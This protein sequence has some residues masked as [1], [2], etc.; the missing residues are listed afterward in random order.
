MIFEFTSPDG[1]TYEVEGPEGSTPEDAFKRLQAHI[2]R[3]PDTNTHF[4]R[5][6]V[7]ATSIPETLA[8]I[9]GL[10][11]AAFRGVQWLRKKFGD[12]ATKADAEKTISRLDALPSIK[13][14]IEEDLGIPTSPQEEA[15]R[16]G[17]KFDR[18]LEALTEGVKMATGTLALG[19]T[20]RLAALA[21]AGAGT[22][23]LVDQEYG[24]LAGGIGGTLLGAKW[25]SAA[26]KRA[27]GKNA[28]TSDA[29]EKQAD[30]AFARMRQS[31]AVVSQS[32]LQRLGQRI[33]ADLNRQNFRPSLHPQTAIIA[34]ELSD[35]I[36]KGIAQYTLPGGVLRSGAAPM[37]FEQLHN[38]R[39]VIDAA[40][41]NA[42]S[43]LM[44]GQPATEDMRLLSRMRSKLNDFLGNLQQSD[45]VG[46]NALQAAAALK[47][48]SRAHQKLVKLR[49]IEDL[50]ERARNNAPGFSQASLDKSIRDQFKNL[51]NKPRML[52]MFSPAE[53]AQIRMIS[54]SSM[55]MA[56]IRRLGGMSPRGT[57]TN[58][59][60]MAHVAI[61][62]AVGVP[63]AAATMGARA[64]AERSRKLAVRDLQELIRLGQANRAPPVLPIA[65]PGIGASALNLSGE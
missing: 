62:P 35:D 63:F 26:A 57:L 11:V 28:P 49:V 32:S 27:A 9:G 15:K 30:D 45:V 12:D 8:E 44:P 52:R 3:T 55:P 43:K 31:G 54:R 2:G 61:N 39:K 38:F 21:G 6:R 58:M 60:H 1:K 17:V 46:G 51:A 65:L 20:G 56:L 23:S 5:A 18:P 4:N 48:G 42:M 34:K 53:Q 59:G 36:T 64:I 14:G 47:E 22:G 13:K 37:Q 7:V 40:N 16:L 50:L 41:K 24:P 25:A 29:I 19:G 10:P 33:E